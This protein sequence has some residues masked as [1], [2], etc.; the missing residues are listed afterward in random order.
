MRPALESQMKSPLLPDPP[1]CLAAVALLSAGCASPAER[2][3]AQRPD[4]KPAI[5]EAILQKRVVLGMFPDEA[6]AA[7]GD[8]LYNV[9]P[10]KKRW[11]D[12]AIPPQVIFS[13]RAHPDSSYIKMTF[14]TATQ[15]NTPEP[16]SFSVGFRHGRAVAITR[17]LQ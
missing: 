10:D 15:F 9:R 7:A 17:E 1:V 3:L 8:F 11:G 16:V 2:Y 14:C 13:Q 12:N 5:R 4:I 6:H